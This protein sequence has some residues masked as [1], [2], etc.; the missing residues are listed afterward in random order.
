MNIGVAIV[1]DEKRKEKLL[2]LGLGEFI[3]PE[4]IVSS[5]LEAIKLFRKEMMREAE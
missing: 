2:K 4:F 1:S 3:A 5:Q